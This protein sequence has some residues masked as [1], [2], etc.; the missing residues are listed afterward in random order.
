MIYAEGPGPATTPRTRA[1]ARHILDNYYI[2][3]AR[4]GSVLEIWGYTDRMTYAPGDRVELRVSTTAETWALEIGR[5]GHRYE[6]LLHET[7]LKGVHQD[8]PHNCSVRG[9]DW[10]VAYDFTIPDDWREGVSCH[11]YRRTGWRPG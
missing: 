6:P 9:C 4:D 5:D 8:T 1:K 3:P 2:G 7:G 10:D 11:A